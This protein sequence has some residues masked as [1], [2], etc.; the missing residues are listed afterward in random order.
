MMNNQHYQMKQDI[1]SISEQIA[2]IVKKSQEQGEKH[3][4]ENPEVKVENTQV[5]TDKKT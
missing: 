5:H 1:T 4:N 3:K 2:A